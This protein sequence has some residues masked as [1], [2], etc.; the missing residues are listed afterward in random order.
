[1][2]KIAYI[3]NT[4]PKYSETFILEEL[5]YLQ[6]MG[7]DLRI[8]SRWHDFSFMNDKIVQSG[9]L[10]FCRYEECRSPGAAAGLK[11]IAALAWK[12]LRS[13]EFR[14]SFFIS[15]F[16]KKNILQR[17]SEAEYEGQVR[18]PFVRACLIGFKLLYELLVCSYRFGNLSAARHHLSTKDEIFEPDHIHCP[19]LFPWDVVKTKIITTQYPWVPYTVTLRSKDIF[20]EV[21]DQRYGRIRESLI[22]HASQV[23]A[24]SEYNK[25]ILTPKF[26]IMR[27]MEVIHSSIDVGLFNPSWQQKSPNNSIVCVARLV[28]K[29][30]LHILIDACAILR[31]EGLLFKLSI[32]GDGP[33]K[34]DIDKQ[35]RSLQLDNFVKA[36]GPRTQNEIVKILDQANVFVLPCLVAPDGDRDMLPNSIK[37]AM[38]MKL[39]VVTSDVSGIEEL[40]LDGINGLLFLAG[41][42]SS[43]ANAMRRALVDVEFAKFAGENARATIVESFSIDS[44]GRKFEAALSGLSCV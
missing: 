10:Q 5:L 18:A 36:I 19:F 7:H 8:Y 3:R 24:I 40:V 41:D 39:I 33:L 23:F 25:R 11:T 32:V 29:K 44:E 17:K 20:A 14:A 16:P 6:G 22:E 31:E 21:K 37:E 4:F 43:L 35:I 2:L 34:D 13:K 42:S 26:R 30:G 9:L 15:Y 38:A 12:L 28:H 27:G 1:M